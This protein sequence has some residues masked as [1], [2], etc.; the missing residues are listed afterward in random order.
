[1]ATNQ[2]SSATEL[3]AAASMSA[4]LQAELARAKEKLDKSNKA[5][6]A[7]QAEAARAA[8]DLADAQAKASAR[9]AALES[10][11]AAL[12]ASVRTLTSQVEDLQDE[13]A[14]LMA[15]A[16]GQQQALAASARDKA[17]VVA[18]AERAAEVS[19]AAISQYAAQVAALSDGLRA[20]QKQAKQTQNLLTISQEQR[21][22][23]EEAN[24]QLHAE[25]DGI[26]AA[27][28]AGTA[29]NLGGG[30]GG[31]GDE[32]Y[33]GEGAGLDGGSL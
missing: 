17:A 24:A 25:L 28:L 22:T 12:E 33:G 13:R 3:R 9:T 2:E 21:R 19:R 18:E 23:L 10:N 1:L 5:R 31:G 6:M 30:A 16:E 11:V 27:S 20:V 26:Y 8:S 14:H 15:Q 4:E 29:A 7:L 32:G